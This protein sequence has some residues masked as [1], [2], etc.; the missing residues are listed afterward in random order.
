MT[1][2]S[3]THELPI[4]PQGRHWLH[5]MV[6]HIRVLGLLRGLKYWRIENACIRE[7]QRVLEWA[8]NCE[9]EAN[10]CNLCG[11][12]HGEAMMNGWARELRSVHRAYVPN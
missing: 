9:R 4:R 2:R 1:P 12:K 7:P 8:A 3:T 5:R 11:D 10:R 6:R